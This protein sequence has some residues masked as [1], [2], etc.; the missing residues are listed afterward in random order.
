MA[1]PFK[2]FLFQNPDENANRHLLERLYATENPGEIDPSIPKTGGWGA[3][4]TPDEIR[5]SL[6]SGNGR[7]VTVDG[8]YI[9]DENLKG[10]VDQ[11]TL[12]I[13]EELEHE[14]YPTIYRHRPKG[15]LPRLIEPHAKWYDAHDYQNSDLGNNFFVELR[16][17]PLQRLI[18]WQFVN[19][20]GRDMNN[21]PTTTIVDF[22]KR[23]RILYDQGILRSI[24]ILGSN[25]SFSGNSALRSQRVFQGMSPTKIPTTHYI[26]FISGYD[27]AYRVPA[28]LREVIGL[29]TAIKVMSIY[30]DGRA[31]AVASFSVGVGV[32]HESVSTTQSATSSMYGAR[33]LELTNYLKA[34]Y[35]KNMSRYR[36]MRVAIL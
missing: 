20:I 6:M 24:G 36:S 11:V 3:I 31:A 25:V 35:E 2:G 15:N 22:Q 23:A 14:I 12:A 26:D 1:R 16:K 13:S 32:L 18:T 19:P 28:E 8:S 33:I 29:V 21:E 4:V 9:T 30:G 34:W 7:L 5:Y 10:F 17:K 27:S